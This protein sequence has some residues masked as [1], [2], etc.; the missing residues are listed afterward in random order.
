VRIVGCAVGLIGGLIFAL[1]PLALT[2]GVLLV[3]GEDICLD[4]WP[5]WGPPEDPNVYT[6]CSGHMWER[7]EA[8]WGWFGGPK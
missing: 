2:V 7:H 6:D 3:A 5:C 1:Y 8:G 4:R